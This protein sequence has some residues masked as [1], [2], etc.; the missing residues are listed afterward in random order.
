MYDNLSP[1]LPD[2]GHEMAKLGRAPKTTEF[3]QAW[4][5]HYAAAV[6]AEG[7]S[8]GRLT[9]AGAKRI[10]ER[11]DDLRHFGDNAVDWLE[12]HGQKS[13]DIDKLLGA[14]Y[15]SAL[16][17]GRS[18]AGSNDR[19]SLKEGADLPTAFAPDFF[20]TRGKKIPSSVAAKLGQTAAAA[21]MT[22]TKLDATVASV[23]AEYG[24][25]NLQVSFDLEEINA[26]TAELGG[27]VSFKKALR[28]AID[29]FI[30]D[31]DHQESPLALV[32]EISDGAWTQA[33]PEDTVRWFI[34]RPTASFELNPRVA[35]EDT[36]P[37][38]DGESVA[39]AWVFNLRIGELSDHLHWAI[40]DRT[41][42]NDAYNY[43]F[44]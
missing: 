3:A 25:P 18:V 6:R 11:S 41:G 22:Q 42:N 36:S 29:S 8:R 4:T 37:P 15:A 43:G 1:R 20:V 5:K 34:N 16:D 35:T 31:G 44:N 28:A 24:V 13:V 7:N 12:D 33:T 21:P 23:L 30:N 27:V 2:N 40:V 26:Q 17:A 10:A 9:V 19:I 39:D 32:N 14:G 38:E